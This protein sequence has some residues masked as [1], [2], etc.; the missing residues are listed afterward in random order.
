VITSNTGSNREVAGERAVIVDPESP[1]EISKAVRKIT[2]DKSVRSKL[3]A[4]GT[5]NLGRFSW[6]QSA[7]KILEVML[8]NNA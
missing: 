2:D 5:K 3:I 7:K 1:Y 8:G 6:E 4:D